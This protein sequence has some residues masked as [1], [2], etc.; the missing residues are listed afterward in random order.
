ML[1]VVLYCSYCLLLIGLC[2][3]LSIGLFV[4]FVLFI[5][6][7]IIYIDY[8]SSQGI[9][10]DDHLPDYVS[11]GPTNSVI[12]PQTQTQ[13]QTQTQPDAHATSPIT[14][15][16]SSHISGGS[17]NGS[18]RYNVEGKEQRR[19]RLETVFD[20][21]DEKHNNVEDNNNHDEKLSQSTATPRIIDPIQLQFTQSGGAVNVG[22]PHLLN[23]MGN[24]RRDSLLSDRPSARFNGMPVSLVSGLCVYCVCIVYSVCIVCACGVV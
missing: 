20:G 14:S 18:L 7:M 17:I 16:R 15:H 6:F 10:A 11:T 8:S 23:T 5:L 21:N 12:E 24:S 19:P 22:T 3:L 4:L 2:N 1:L 9:Q 13:T